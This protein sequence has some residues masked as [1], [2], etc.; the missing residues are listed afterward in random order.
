M[1]GAHTASAVAEQGDVITSPAPHRDVH[2][3]QT[4]SEAGEHGAEAKLPAAHTLHREHTASEVL[5]H[6]AAR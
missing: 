3:E 6:A 1:H 2:A 4:V 5:V